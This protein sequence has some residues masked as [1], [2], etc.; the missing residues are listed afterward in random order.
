LLKRSETIEFDGATGRE[1]RIRATAIERAVEDRRDLAVI[2]ELE[3]VALGAERPRRAGK[4]RRLGKRNGHTGL[5]KYWDAHC[6]QGG[7]LKA[8]ER[9]V[10]ADVTG[11]L[12][13]GR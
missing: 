2:F 4:A 1:L 11:T 8:T 13:V 7:G 6:A 10:M 5:H 12:L 9:S 3:Q